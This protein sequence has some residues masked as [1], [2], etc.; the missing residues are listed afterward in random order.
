M[1]NSKLVF[2]I[3][4]I[5][6]AL[7]LFNGIFSAL[8][9][10]LKTENHVTN[11]V[12]EMGTVLWRRNILQNEIAATIPNSQNPRN[13]DQLEKWIDDFRPTDPGHSPGAG[14]SSPNPMDGNVTMNP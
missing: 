4:S 6:V 1:A 11:S 8:G 10:P 13:D 2:S 9:R 3:S 12:K 7:M 5:L 14:H